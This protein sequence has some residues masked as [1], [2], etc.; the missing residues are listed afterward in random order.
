MPLTLEDKVRL[1]SMVDVFESLVRQELVELAYR[2]RDAHLEPGEVLGKLLQEGNE[3]LWVLKEGR[4]QLFVEIPNAGGGEVTLSVVEGGSV[5]GELALG[6]MRSGEVYARALV[7]SLVCSLKT[8]DVQHL[9]ESSPQVGIA[10]VRLL[11]ERLREAEVRLAE[12]AYMQVTARLANL[13]L[14]LGVSEGIMSR[15]GIRIETP[16]T[17][18][19]LGTIIGAKR[20]AV[21][22]AMTELQEEGTVEVVRRRIHI[23]NHEALEREAEGR[24]ATRS[25]SA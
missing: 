23:K 3:E 20:E 18:R 1:L 8:Q 5:F 11:S 10:M 17:H 12:L 15:E 16:Y 21:T 7:P 4:V 22:R 19:Q 14:R 9:I 25:L 24:S 2:A 6:G 13:I